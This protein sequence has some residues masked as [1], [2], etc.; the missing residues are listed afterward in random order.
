MTPRSPR[1]PTAEETGSTTQEACHSDQAPPG[2]QQAPH[3]EGS[4]TRGAPSI[5]QPSRYQDIRVSQDLQGELDSYNEKHRMEVWLPAPTG[6]VWLTF[7]ELSEE[8]SLVPPDFKFKI[9][10][11]EKTKAKLDKD[12]GTWLAK[13]MTGLSVS[14]THLTL[15]TIYSV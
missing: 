5:Q 14:Y 12:F 7:Q 2:F 13:T 1:G 9:E 11:M 6:N 4:K 15:P 8:F 10:V 3:Q